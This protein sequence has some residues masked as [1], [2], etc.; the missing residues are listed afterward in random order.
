[1][2]LGYL[3]GITY[4]LASQHKIPLQEFAPRQ[5]KAAVTGYGAASKEQVA[6]VI[7]RLFRGLEQPK[8]LDMTDAIAVTLCAAWA[9]KSKSNPLSG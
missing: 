5:V 9:S 8:K 6:L 1:M 4:L 2:K 7:A 3:R